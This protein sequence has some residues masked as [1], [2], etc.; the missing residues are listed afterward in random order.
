MDPDGQK[1]V[2]SWR[3][4]DGGIGNYDGR[5]SERTDVSCDTTTRRDA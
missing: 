2:G 3:L 1:T 4:G 5:A